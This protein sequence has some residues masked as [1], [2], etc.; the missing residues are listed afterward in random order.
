MDT[1]KQISIIILCSL[2]IWFFIYSIW[3]GWNIEFKSREIQIKLY[4]YPAKRF[5]I[6]SKNVHDSNEVVESKPEDAF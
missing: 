5:F 1:I 6:K 4:Q 3:N 2:L